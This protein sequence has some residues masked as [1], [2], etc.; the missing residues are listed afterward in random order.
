[1]HW[2][3]SSLHG[4]VLGH[5]MAAADSHCFQTMESMMDTNFLSRAHTNRILFCNL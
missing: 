1:M 4:P 3:L 5:L 2:L